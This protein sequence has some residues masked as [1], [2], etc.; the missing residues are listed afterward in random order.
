MVAYRDSMHLKI[1]ILSKKP[2][3]RTNNNAEFGR[4]HMRKICDFFIRDLAY[5]E[6]IHTHEMSTF[7]TIK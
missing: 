2:R 6:K 7:A 4:L 3:P 1:L 5:A